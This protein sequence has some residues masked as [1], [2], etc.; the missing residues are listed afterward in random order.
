MHLHVCRIYYLQDSNEGDEMTEL[1]RLMRQLI[2]ATC[3][4][5]CVVTA[6]AE[7]L[8]HEV[9]KGLMAEYS[10]FTNDGTFVRGG[11]AQHGVGAD[12]KVRLFYFIYKD[13]VATSWGG[14]IPNT[15]VSGFGTGNLIVNVNTCDINPT[16]ACGV[17]KITWKA[18]TDKSRFVSGIQSRRQ[19]NIMSRTVG[20]Y[21]YNMADVTGSIT[22]ID[23]ST[24]SRMYG[25]MGYD[26]SV[27]HT[28]S[29]V[30]N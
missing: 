5:G 3:F 22:G 29:I 15:T 4:A 17:V 19:G 13:Q 25:R 10:G 2:F 18:N 21:S 16:A 1:K 27:T 12:K 26:Y 6:N 24:V 20:T 7:V 11:I 14:Y 28:I 9:N 8:V 30:N 23:L